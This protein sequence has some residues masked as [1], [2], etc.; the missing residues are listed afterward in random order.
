MHKGEIIPPISFC[1]WCLGLILFGLVCY[2]SVAQAK[3]DNQQKGI[4]LLNDTA[5]A[6]ESSNP[7]LSKEFTQLAD[8]QEKEWEAQNAGK[9]KAPAAL[10]VADRAQRIKLLKQAAG[11]VAPLYP[12]M[13]RDLGRMADDTALAGITVGM[14]ENDFWALYPKDHLRNFRHI[15]P[16]DWLTYNEPVDDPFDALITFHFNGDKLAAWKF[17]DRPEVVKEYL[18]E[19]CFYQP[20][21][22]TYYALQDVLERMPYK[23]FLS[24]TRRE[25]PMLFTEFYNEGT[26][27]FA[28]SSEFIVNSEYPPC[29][30][31]GFTIVKLGMSLGLA[32]TKGPIEGVV[33]HEI[34][35]RVL[36]TIRK[37]NANC[38][39]ERRAN[40][41]IIK[42][43]FGKEFKEASRLFGQKKGDP[44]GCQEVPH[45]KKGKSVIKK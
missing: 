13:A 1:R 8:E 43:G 4:I 26:A 7:A 34:A 9:A 24:A 29:C 22:L 33:A 15:G 3:A 40:R 31:E 17:N 35:H 6:L 5:A 41:L 38:D 42:W 36:D 2:P 11:A 18:G 25:R 21:S 37:G 19:F 16:D 14:S 20:P 30:Q 10:S 12:M 39:G 23:D 27:R 44:A 32:K 28:S 45:L